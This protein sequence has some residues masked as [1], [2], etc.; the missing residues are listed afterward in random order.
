MDVLR[1]KIIVQDG[2]SH[3]IIAVD[4]VYDSTGDARTSLLA[5]RNGQLSS[6]YY[7]DFHDGAFDIYS[8]ATTA[9]EAC[10]KYADEN[11]EEVA[12]AE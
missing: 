5:S 11:A 2:I 12:A 9:A 3:E 10:Q 4:K 1:G 6:F 8:S 7:D